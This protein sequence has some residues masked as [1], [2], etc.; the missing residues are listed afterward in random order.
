MTYLC[1]NCN[2]KCITSRNKTN[3]YCDNKCQQEF[4][5]N[6]LVNH[7]LNGIISPLNQNNVLK[8]WARKY[9]LKKANYKCEQCG[10]NQKNLYSNKIPLETDHI[11]GNHQNNKL[12]NLRVL[13][14]N[15]HSLTPTYKN[16]NKGHGRPR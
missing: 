7:W 8:P 1:K 15:C 12:E 16:S 14:P 5:N 2:K 3:Q 11:D 10:W 9:L 6:K 13:C 4:Q